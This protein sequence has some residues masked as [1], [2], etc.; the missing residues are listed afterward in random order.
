MRANV[1]GFMRL[2]GVPLGRY[3]ARRSARRSTRAE[4]YINRENRGINTLLNVEA[5]PLVRTRTSDRV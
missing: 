5:H 3:V 4:D 1:Y 2:R